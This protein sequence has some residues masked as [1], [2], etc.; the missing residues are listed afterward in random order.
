[1]KIIRMNQEIFLTT[2]SDNFADNYY[3]KN[4]SL[5]NCERH[6]CFARGVLFQSIVIGFIL[7]VSKVH[8]AAYCVLVC[9]RPAC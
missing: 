1:M 8:T 6:V 5:C 3:N 4:A 7:F 9:K 2:I